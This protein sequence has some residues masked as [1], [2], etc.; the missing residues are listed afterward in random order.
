VVAYELAGMR[1]AAKVEESDGEGEEDLPVSAPAVAGSSN[2][3]QIPVSAPV[4]AG[5]SNTP[6][7]MHV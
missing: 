3:P 1:T 4:V 5:S 7:I 2:T 6:Q